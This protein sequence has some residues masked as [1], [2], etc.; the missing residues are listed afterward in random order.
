MTPR[1]GGDGPAPAEWGVGARIAWLT[2]FVGIA[3]N[4]A[5]V[6]VSYGRLSERVTG[7]GDN[8]GRVERK[9]DRLQEKTDSHD[10]RIQTLEDLPEHRARIY[11]RGG[12]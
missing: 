3:I 6:A 10:V 4:I 12:R 8:V 11:G 7:V 1:G 2:L 9:V 5:A